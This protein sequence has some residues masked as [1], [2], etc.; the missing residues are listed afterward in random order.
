MK[1]FILLV[2]IIIQFFICCAKAPSEPEWDYPLE[3][4][5]K[6]A[7]SATDSLNY[8]GTYG[9]SS[10][11]IDVDGQI[12]NYVYYSIN[13]ENSEDEVF[14]DFQKNQVEGTLTVLLLLKENHIGYWTYDTLIQAS[15]SASYGSVYVSWKP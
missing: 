6:V 7:G 4:S 10:I 9:N 14:A 8:F 3:I 2:F 1:K 5:I 13:V 11:S 15:T 12:P